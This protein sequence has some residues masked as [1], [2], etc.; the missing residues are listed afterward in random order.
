MGGGEEEGEGG[1]GQKAIYNPCLPALQTI[2][3]AHIRKMIMI[4]TV[5]LAP[6]KSQDPL[7]HMGPQQNQTKKKISNNSKCANLA[8]ML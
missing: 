7:S 3:S 6:T 2:H 8:E 1:E 5:R 4:T